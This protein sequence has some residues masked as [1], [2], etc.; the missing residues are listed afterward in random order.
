MFIYHDPKIHLPATQQIA[1]D[2]W[3][4][5]FPFWRVDPVTGEALL[6]PPSGIGPIDSWIDSPIWTTD[7]RS[8]G[9][10]VDLIADK[11]GIES[12]CWLVH[13]WSYTAELF[14]RKT[15]DWR[16]LT[17]LQSVGENW[18]QRNLVWTGV[19]LGGG[20][21]WAKHDPSY[22]AQMKQYAI[23]CANMFTRP[24]ASG[25]LLTANCP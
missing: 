3:V 17:D 24:A 18:L 8:G 19:K 4:L 22:I 7:Y 2:Q 5:E 21:V 23:N 20:F 9:N 10:F 6:I 13:D 25:Q 12:P 11:L 1:A 15:C 14:P 16:L